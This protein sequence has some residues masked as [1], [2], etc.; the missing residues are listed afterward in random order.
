[1]FKP[2]EAI[3]KSLETWYD[4]DHPLHLDPLH[5]A[6]GLAG[7]AGELLDLLKKERFKDGV[8]WWDCVHCNGS[9]EVHSSNLT[10]QTGF[11]NCEYAPKILDKLG[12]LWYY[13]R[14]LAYQYKVELESP[15]LANIRYDFDIILTRLNLD[16]ATFL[17]ELIV[18]ARYNPELLDRVYYSLHYC[19]EKLDCTLDQLTELN[20]DKLKDG[21][22]HGWKKTAP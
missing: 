6:I 11:A 20:Y 9:K 4:Q 15:E 1:M 13:L 14:I 3:L 21:D 12:N 19:L 16:A 22:H 10:I 5:P 8:S 18:N 2:D 7:E 17:N